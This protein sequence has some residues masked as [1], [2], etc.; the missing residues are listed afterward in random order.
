MK[1]EAATGWRPPAQTHWV[2]GL[3]GDFQELLLGSS[4][5]LTGFLQVLLQLICLLGPAKKGGA[6]SSPEDDRWRREIPLPPYICREEGP[7]ITLK[8]APEQANKDGGGWGGQ[9][10]EIRTYKAR[11]TFPGIVRLNR[12]KH[13]GECASVYLKA[14]GPE[15][16]RA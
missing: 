7:G 16:S 12:A 11:T 6:V 15:Q 8:M 14:E 4:L 5:G 13:C 3:G 2:C 10:H 9:L 1:S